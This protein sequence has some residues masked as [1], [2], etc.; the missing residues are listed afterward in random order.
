MKRSEGAAIPYSA[1]PECLS[2]AYEHNLLKLIHL[3]HLK[4]I[5]QY[6]HTISRILRNK[7]VT[8]LH[9][10]GLHFLSEDCPR[11]QPQVIEI[12]DW[13]SDVYFWVAFFVRE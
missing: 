5:K 8:F 10:Q 7:R 2:N 3:L 4:N 13:T 9:S 11:I 12:T 6:F 1:F